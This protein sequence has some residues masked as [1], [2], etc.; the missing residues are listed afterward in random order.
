MFGVIDGADEIPA[1]IDRIAFL[2]ANYNFDAAKH[3]E[4]LERWLK[5]DDASGGLWSSLRRSGNHA[6]RQEGSRPPAARIGPPAA[7]AMPWARCFRSPKRP[8]RRFRKSIGLDGRIHFFVHPN[9]QNKILHTVLVGEMN[10]LV[11]AATLGTPRRKVGQ[12]WWAARVHEMGASRADGAVK[13]ARPAIALRK[14]HRRYKLR[15]AREDESTI[16]SR[17]SRSRSCRRGRRMRSVDRS[18]SK[19]SQGLRSTDREA[20]IQREISAGNFPDF[21]RQFK[22]GADCRHDQGRRTRTSRPRSK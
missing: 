9:P 19:V 20:A 5:G 10:G 15:R 14:L 13:P 21:L 16:S 7:C 6:Q 4:K 2:D 12:I 22:V 3:T 18:S 17:R 1:Y 8:T 11:H